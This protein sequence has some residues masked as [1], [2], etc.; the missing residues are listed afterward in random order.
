[1]KVKLGAVIPTVQYG[2]IQ[3]EFESD[4]AD[5]LPKLEA[6][7]QALWAKYAERPLNV[8]GG[9]GKRL[10]AF[11]GGEIDYD[12]ASHT[13]TWEGHTYLSG[14]QYAQ[15]F[16]K[17]FDSQNISEAMAKRDGGDAQELRDMWKLKSETSMGFGTAIHSALELY[18][19]YQ[20]LHD[21]PIIK[22]AVEGFY[23]DRKNEQAEYEALIVDH[24]KKHA[25]Q[26]DRLLI[27]GKNSCRVQDFKTNADIKK[28]LDI[29][30][31][32]LEFYAEIVKAG[33]WKVEGL[34]IFWW[35]GE[36]ETFSK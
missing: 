18:G 23:K 32:Q 12:D 8:V 13:Y 1:M 20:N 16:A 15:Q 26:V 34:D 14:S 9:A 6:Q 33:G 17:P 2:N 10:K 30:W 3:P 31:K 7:I 5:D 22:K 19:R 21:H 24:D 29:Y 36:W 35:N 28:S 27:T 4:N 11:V 25:G